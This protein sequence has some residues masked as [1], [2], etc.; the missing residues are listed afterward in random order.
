[1]KS[2]AIKQKF[3]RGAILLFFSLVYKQALAQ[4]RLLTD[5][6]GRLSAV[7]NLERFE[8]QLTSFNWHGTDN[9]L[10]L[11]QINAGFAIAGFNMAQTNGLYK[12]PQEAKQLGHL[13]FGASGLNTFKGWR[14]YGEFGYQHLYRDSVNFS[15]VARPYG[16]NPFITADSIGG[17]WKGDQ[18]R[19]KLQI[20][21][22]D[23]GKW[24]LASSIDYLTEQANRRNDPRPL[25]RY[26]DATISQSIGYQL[27]NGDIIAAKA[28]YQ[29]KTEEVET[30]QFTTINYKLY[31]LR[32]YGTRDFVPV[33]SAQR[34]TDAYGWHAGASYFH[35][36]LRS[37]FFVQGQFAYLSKDVE[38]GSLRNPSTNILEPLLVG[39]YDEMKYRLKI[40]YQRKLSVQKGWNAKLFAS[41][42]DGAGYDPNFAGIN[43]SHYFIDI[44]GEFAYWRPFAN[45]SWAKITYQPSWH[46]INYNEV[47]AKTDWL[48]TQFRQ[49]LTLVWMKQWNRK[50]RWEL[51]PSLGYNLP[52]SGDLV[53]NRPTV[54]SLLLVRPDF[55]YAN[56]SYFKTELGLGLT[57][58]SNQFTY[59]LNGQISQ[60]TTADMGN[61]RHL[62]LSF[63]ILF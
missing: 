49:E 46:S 4:E 39:G 57:Y 53:I 58:L 62:G 23:L 35:E 40:G 19:A 9:A 41:I 48:V 24:R 44:D 10:A 32:G 12:R 17:N 29:H 18:L 1:M 45:N 22:P 55:A 2:I 61:R 13:G 28:G 15:N 34:Y 54:I 25:Y 43:P 42:T 33:I 56:Q 27:A 31:S 7:V 5:T 30:G 37:S 21:Y 16:G 50:W 51:S 8:K 59:R 36:G 26:L 47:I 20:A 6:S 63:Q 14:F 11:K 60:L 52:L 38:D 3:W